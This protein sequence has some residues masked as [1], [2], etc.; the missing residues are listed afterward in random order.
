MVDQAPL[1][2]TIRP[3]GATPPNV[4]SGDFGG[5]Q[6]APQGSDLDSYLDAAPPNTQSQT[7]DASGYAPVGQQPPAKAANSLDDFLGKGEAKSPTLTEGMNNDAILKAV[8]YNDQHI[9]DMKQ[10]PS[11][12]LAVAMDGPDFL[13]KELSNPGHIKSLIMTDPY[14]GGLVHGADQTALSTARYMALGLN[15]IGAVP[16]TTPAVIDALSRVTEAAY[17]SSVDTLRQTMGTNPHADAIPQFL[18]GLALGGLGIGK[19]APTAAAVA[20]SPLAI[21]LLQAGGSL[22]KGATVAAATA[23]AFDSMHDLTPGVGQEYNNR[24]AGRVGDDA[25]WGALFAA[26]T[27]TLIR[28]AL[29]AGKLV[30][31]TEAAARIQRILATVQQGLASTPDKYKAVAADLGKLFKS[32]EYADREMTFAQHGVTPTIGDVTKS[33]PQVRTEQTSKNFPMGLANFRDKTQQ[34]QLK[35]AATKYSVEQYDKMINTKWGSLDELEEAAKGQGDYANRAKEVLNILKSETG[36]PA[37]RAIKADLGAQDVRRLIIKAKLYAARDALA[38]Q[39]AVN[40]ARPLEA[41]KQIMANESKSALPNKGMMADVGQI[42]QFLENGPSSQTYD[43]YVATVNSLEGLIG[44]YGDN[45]DRQLI[46]LKDAF[47]GALDDFTNNVTK[48]SKAERYG[49]DAKGTAE[50]FKGSAG[51]GYVLDVVRPAGTKDAEPGVRSFTSKEEARDAGV[52]GQLEGKQINL[53]SPVIVEGAKGRA[54]FIKKLGLD[55]DATNEDINADAVNYAKGTGHD[56]VVFTKNGFPRQII[57]MT[58]WKKEIGNATTKAD[59]YFKRT[60]GPTVGKGGMMDATHNIVESGLNSHP[61]QIVGNMIKAGQTDKAQAFYNTLGPRG[62]AAVQSEIIQRAI[63]AG[64]DDLGRVDPTK[65]ARNLFKTIDEAKVFFRGEDRWRLEGFLKLMAESKEMAP[66]TH[67]SHMMGGL[68]GFEML[69]SV[70]EGVLRGSVHEA[71]ATAAVQVTGTV[72]ASKVISAYS[73]NP[74]IRHLLLAASD[75]GSGTERLRVI[76]NKFQTA[77]SKAIGGAAGNQGD[78]NGNDGSN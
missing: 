33:V 68:I 66:G 60:Y 42:Q 47:N 3:P 8:G 46:K 9:A 53:R 74:K 62:R 49:T 56:G 11:Y 1:Q 48:F 35:A 28:G 18:G 78:Q 20:Q 4:Q 5:G 73:S 30:N 27:H 24:A 45:A 37:S 17:H 22:I 15:A 29:T 72:G 21:R 70:M 71:V 65:V 25:M 10:D 61:D 34:G 2:V 58:G 14:I 40:P 69:N 13:N 16:D 59:D 39:A 77:L 31:K 41:V 7:T 43:K 23:P 36:T 64:T 6:G 51:K 12:K 76:Y 19:A 75:A 63:D 67:G 54:E 55:V 57:D 32:Q 38:G 50:Y 44:K 52:T 26:G